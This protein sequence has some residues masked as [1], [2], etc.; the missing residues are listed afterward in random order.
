MKRLRLHYKHKTIRYFHCGEY[1]DK[2]NRPHYHA[3]LFNHA[4]TDDEN[5][6]LY[7]TSNDN[8]L[9]ISPILTE[10]W[11]KGFTTIGSLTF[12]S[13]A[14][15]ARYIMKKINGDQAYEH[16]MRSDCY[17]Q[18]F[19]VEP[20]YTTMS[21]KPGIGKGWYDKWKDD[22]YPED[23][24]VVGTKE[25]LPP[26]YYDKNYEID[27]PKEHK[28]LKK[29]RVKRAALSYNNNTPER[30]AVREKVKQASTKRLKRTL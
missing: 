13:A 22:V 21:R 8:Q 15:T 10:I 29:N 19:H 1:G 11:G 30:L 12:E 17:G 27:A 20:E 16:Y 2:D 4:F 14:Y 3:C 26:K 18:M 24:L 25:M 28:N 5:R 23:H 6:I 9:W 7:S